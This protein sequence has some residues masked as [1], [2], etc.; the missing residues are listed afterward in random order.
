[1]DNRETRLGAKGLRVAG[2]RAGTQDTQE[3]KP[4]GALHDD[5]L[6][7]RDENGW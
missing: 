4:Y 2:Q 7:I 3:Q 5:D 6:V 1:M